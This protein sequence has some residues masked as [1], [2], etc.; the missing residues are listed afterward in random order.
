[1]TRNITVEGPGGTLDG[2]RPEKPGSKEDKV[3][4]SNKIE[5]EQFLAQAS[6][7][8]ESEGW[9]N[10]LTLAEAI[11]ECKSTGLSAKLYRYSE[12]YESDETRLAY[13]IDSLGNWR[14]V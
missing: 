10:N 2:H 6:G 12:E 11:E 1:M 4:K 9:E 7:N 14:A 8:S 5:T 3:K 13:V